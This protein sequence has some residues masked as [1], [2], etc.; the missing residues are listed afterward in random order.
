MLTHRPARF[1]LGDPTTETF[2]CTCSESVLLALA[3]TLQ[4]PATSSVASP[5]AATSRN[6]RTCYAKSSLRKQALQDSAF[7]VTLTRLS[8]VESGPKCRTQV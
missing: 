3:P 5:A 8:I 1:I 6:T 7:H 2:G 4:L